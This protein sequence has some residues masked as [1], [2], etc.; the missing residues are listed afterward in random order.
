MYYWKPEEKSSIILILQC[1]W[2]TAVVW[3]SSQQPALQLWGNFSF[4]YTNWSFLRAGH[5]WEEF[6]APLYFL[7]WVS[8]H[9]LHCL[10]SS[11]SS[12]S[13]LLCAG[14]CC[15]LCVENVSYKHLY[16]L[17]GEYTHYLQCSG[18]WCASKLLLQW[19]L[20]PKCDCGIVHYQE[21]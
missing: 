4:C 14:L 2:E 21:W 9:G 11:R 7:P 6:I 13:C 16:L 8:S 19:I 5:V 12:H 18:P 15:S 20:L 3:L 1:P 17:P 10:H